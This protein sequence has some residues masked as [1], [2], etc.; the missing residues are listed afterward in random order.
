MKKRSSR[1]AL[2]VL[3]MHRSGT[4]AMAGLLGEMG[5][6]LPNDLMAAAEMNAKGFFESNKITYLNE[7]LLASAGMTWFDL[8]RFPDSWYDSPKAPE[9]HRRATVALTEEFG[10]SGLFVMKDP[11]NCR[12]IPFWEAAL[13]E[14]DAQ[15]AYVCIHRD[16]VEVAASLMR[17][18]GYEPL[19]GQILWLRHVLDAEFAT[20][21][22]KRIF[23]SYEQLLSDW[24]GL[25]GRISAD[26]ELVFPRSVQTASR[27]VQ[28]FLSRDLK[29]LS[30][31]KL[32]LAR[33]DETSDWLAAT[34]GVL[35]RWSLTGEDSSDHAIL[36]HVRGALDASSDTMIPVFDELLARYR[37][38]IHARAL[39]GDGQLQRLEEQLE[40][41]ETNLRN[42]EANLL[43]IHQA[44]HEKSILAQDL[45]G[46]LDRRTME[47]VK[48][49]KRPIR[50]LRKYLE[51]KALRALSGGSSPLP[52]KTK[53]R[54]LRSANKR[55]PGRYL[56]RTDNPVAPLV[57]APRATISG[58]GQIS[59]RS[60][61]P[62][63]IIV[64]HDASRTG[65]PILALNMAKA[66]SARYNIVTI[67]LRGGDLV[68]DFRQVSTQVYVA[69]HADSSGAMFATMIEAISAKAPPAF[70]VVNS[71]ES[72]HILGAL[73]DRCIP[74]VALFHEFASYTVPKTAFTDALLL[75]DEVVFSTELTIR[76]AL[77]QTSFVRTPRFHVLAQG[78]CEVPRRDSDETLRQMERDRLT[79]LLRPGGENT[80]E[81]LVIGAGYVQMRKGVDLFIDVARRVLSTEE[82]RNARFAWIGAGYDP[83]RDAAYS[84]YLKDQ[85]ERAGLTDRMLMLGETSEIEHVYRLSNT[86]LLTSRLDPL[87][88]VAIDALTE[89]VPVICF[90]KTTGIADLLTEAGLR[91]ASVADYL[92]TQQ[93]AD[94]VLRLIRSPQTYRQVCSNSTTFAA[95]A[96]DFTAYATRIEALGLETA[97]AFARE[98]EDA[99]A[100][101]AATDFDPVFVMP[102]RKATPSR[103]DAAKYYL[104]V[105]RRVEAPRRP[106]PGFNQL[107]YARHLETEGVTEV[108]AYAEFLRR[109]RP[110]GPWLRRVI[111]EGDSAVL[112]DGKTPP[113]TVLHIHAYYPDVV[114]MIAERL[115][116]NETR[117]DLFINAGDRK[118]LNAALEAFKDY[119]G[120]IAEA[121]VAV[122][123][124][125]DIGSFLTEFGPELVREYD[126]IG[127]IH[128]KKSA[129]LSDRDLVDR[130]VRFL[131]E[132]VI[133]GRQGGAM[134]DRI[135]AQF[136]EN[137]RL[138]IVFPADPNILAW[139]GNEEIARKLAP[140]LALEELPEFIDFPIG[141]MFWVR[142]AAL[143]P[144]VAMGLGWNDYPSEPVPYD[145]TIL[146]A[147]ERMFGLVAESRGLEVAVTNIKGVTR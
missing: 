67:C 4:S 41:A 42:R 107:V 56:P 76:N 69:E 101:E 70:A 68:G 87:P 32:E 131:Y 111:R 82:G 35:S 53:S 59:F 46:E 64:S 91:E 115:A 58:H 40:E 51:F 133:G 147:I 83:E 21:G 81:F 3:G 130:W 141:S 20:R 39:I 19:F 97:V 17:W 132:N 6:D 14:L 84:V 79:A 89:G 71:I 27:G 11:R 85:I 13:N 57:D 114:G 26:L 22:K 72:R 95:Q 48:A 121:R 24:R 63:A 123:R 2:I 36:D 100:I 44:L 55:D 52:L 93:A 146:H 73:R 60:D 66:L 118:S 102:G 88:N 78:R 23:V 137:E 125:R 124:G 103:S 61:L 105:N 140:R 29:H 62:I 10:E 7:D 33:L 119:R 99:A 75:A 15:P 109:G 47:L 135:I 65:A 49:Q 128:T 50:N 80:G 8:N 98:A 9:F 5:C 142:A 143:E 127:H 34:L 1:T 18:A 31:E 28:K 110:A 77:D 92:D 122:N 116:V 74:S 117:P 120:R 54:F 43:A 104:T 129:T 16:P 25:V 126:L 86:L 144:F 145:G 12:L 45:M 113:R 30:S 106:E 38:S 112:P 139:S 37:E 96:F 90:D 136:A 134:M 108:D 138:G 94:R